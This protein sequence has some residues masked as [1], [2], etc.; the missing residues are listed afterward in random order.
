MLN[1]IEPFRAYNTE[2]ESKPSEDGEQVREKVIIASPMETSNAS[3]LEGGFRNGKDD[4]DRNDSE[5]T[6]PQTRIFWFGIL[7]IFVLDSIGLLIVFLGL[8]INRSIRAIFRF[9]LGWLAE[10][11]LNGGDRIG[12]DEKCKRNCRDT[13]LHPDRHDGKCQRKK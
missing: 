12:K 10:P 8:T 7:R 1:D 13:G 3:S 2:Q 5:Q 4:I 9:L 11:A 6:L